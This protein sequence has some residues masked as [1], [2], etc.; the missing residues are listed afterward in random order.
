MALELLEDLVVLACQVQTVLRGRECQGVLVALLLLGAQQV[1]LL[2]SHH[3]VL[4]LLA[5][6][7]DLACLAFQPQRIQVV[8]GDQGGLGDQDFQTL[9]FL[10]DLVVLLV[11]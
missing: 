2:L 4:C 5:F 8:L 11:Q 10:Q 6:L 3:L 1:Q 9:A 7:V